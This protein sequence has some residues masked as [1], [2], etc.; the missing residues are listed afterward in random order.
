MRLHAASLVED[1]KSLRDGTLDLLAHVDEICARVDAIDQDLCALVPEEGRN[2]RLHWEARALADRFR[3]PD[4]R[5]RLFGAPVGVMDV[6][7]VDGLPTRAGSDLPPET[8]AGPEADVVSRLRAAGALILGKTTTEEFA[9]K[10]EP[11]PTRNPRN[12]AHTP[13]GPSSGSAAAVAAGLCP[14]A[15]GTQT[16][17]S[18]IGPAAFC[19]AVGLK[20]SHGRVPLDG[21]VLSAPSL[22]SLGFFTQDVASAELAAA[23]AVEGWRSARGAVL[24]VLAVPEG[25]F[26]SFL[27]PD[28]SEAFG[29]QVRLLEDSAYH[30]VRLPV[31]W[32]DDPQDVFKRLL[33]LHL[34]EMARVHRKWFEEHSS[35]YGKAAGRAIQLGSAIKSQSLADLRADQQDLRARLTAK[36]AWAGVDLWVCPSSAGPAPEGFEVTGW[37]GMTGAWSYAGLPAISVPA[38]V[39]RNN[40]PLGLQAVARWNDDERMVAWAAGIEHV[41]S[42]HGES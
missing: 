35:A 10:G 5:P 27:V 36:M 32:D 37:S 19:G 41:L 22:E 30:V 38:G 33:D 14:L 13:G 4:R 39:A 17:R 34:G 29:R 31:P 28:A 1:V 3:D 25:K 11:P 15:L 24:P 6:F 8:F 9:F 42:E 23:A 40:L 26:M 12:P 18:V 7:R 20:L 16:Q 21:V 2:H